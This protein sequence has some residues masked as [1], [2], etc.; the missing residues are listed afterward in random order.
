MRF[1]VTE[2]SH[3]GEMVG[4]CVALVPIESVPH[5]EFKALTRESRAVVRTGECSPYANVILRSGV[6]F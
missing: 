4:G 1:G 6:I 3:S 5:T 2:L